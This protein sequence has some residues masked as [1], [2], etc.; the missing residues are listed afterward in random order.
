MGS[1]GVKAVSLSANSVSSVIKGSEGGQKESVLKV[2]QSV[3]AKNAQLGNGLLSMLQHV[4][5]V[6][7]GASGIY[8]ANMH[9]N[10]AQLAN[11]NRI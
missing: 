11:F 1:M 7:L 10:T 6:L 8:Q 3:L 2:Q 9:A 5:C 4:Q